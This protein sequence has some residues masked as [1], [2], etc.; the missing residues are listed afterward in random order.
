MVEVERVTE[1]S[2]EEREEVLK[3]GRAAFPFPQSALVHESSHMLAVRHEG[4]IV[5]GT[6]SEIFEPKDGEKVG[7]VTWIFTSEVARGLHAGEAVLDTTVD[8]LEE[9]GCDA[10]VAIVEWGNTSSSKLF[11]SQGFERTSAGDVIDEYGLG[12]TARVW[13]T[14]MYF[15]ALGYDLWTKNLVDERQTEKPAN[16]DSLL[17]LTGSLGVNTALFVVAV[18]SLFG[19]GT[20]AEYPAYVVLIPLFFLAVRYVPTR[21]AVARDDDEWRYHSWGN[22]YPFASVFAVFGL[23]LP[24]PGNHAPDER[25]WTYREK[26]PLLG[27]TA[28]VSSLLT[29]VLYGVALADVSS[30]LT[31]P[32]PE[33]VSEIVVYTAWFFLV[34]DLIF[35]SFPFDTYNARVVR[36]WNRGVWFVL[37]LVAVGMLV[38]TFLRLEFVPVL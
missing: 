17:H 16:T 8:Y 36:D 4:E 29:L 7:L 35:P 12:G 1:E 21:L 26:L 18:A 9:Q 37:A 28:F 3:I 27:P 6:I 2:P 30:V 24:V 34:V 22:V 15:P 19:V 13:L 38:F 10:L 14:A 23:F 32:F 20:V 33:T 11:A 31:T 5:G 25:I